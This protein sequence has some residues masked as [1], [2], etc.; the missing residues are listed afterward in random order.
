MVRAYADLRVNLVNHFTEKWVGCCNRPFPEQSHVKILLFPVLPDSG[1]L[2]AVHRC[3]H[4]P[5]DGSVDPNFSSE[6]LKNSSFAGLYHNF[7]FILWLRQHIRQ[8]AT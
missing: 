3:P 8:K 5:P 2:G 4:P 1:L 6:N 7:C